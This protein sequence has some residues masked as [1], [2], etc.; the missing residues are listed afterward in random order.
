LERFKVLISLAVK[1]LFR[2][3]FLLEK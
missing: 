3:S 2:E 1:L